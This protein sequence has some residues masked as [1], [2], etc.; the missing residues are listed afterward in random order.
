LPLG[1]S[2]VEKLGGLEMPKLLRGD[3]NPMPKN[4]ILKFIEKIEI[5][6]G[7]EFYA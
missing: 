5:I 6:Q 4:H 3:P 1:E 7:G 2:I